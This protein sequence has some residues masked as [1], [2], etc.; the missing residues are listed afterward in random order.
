MCDFA[1]Y[2]HILDWRALPVRLAATLAAGLPEGS[3]CMMYLSS[4]RIPDGVQLQA[5]AADALHRLEWRLFGQPGS[6][7]PPSIL[8]RLLGEPD[9]ASD[10]NV[11][12]YA[13]PEEF[14]AACAAIL[15]GG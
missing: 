2:Y 6:R 11:Q 14:D 5:I 13:S 10:S 8:S 9:A 15:R 7:M 3:R 4:R 1:Q 12:S